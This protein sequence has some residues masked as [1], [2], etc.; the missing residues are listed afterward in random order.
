MKAKFEEQNSQQAAL[1]QGEIDAGECIVHVPTKIGQ[2]A[3]FSAASEASAARNEAGFWRDLYHDMDEQ[4]AKVSDT[5][6]GGKN[7]D[8]TAT[9]E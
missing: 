9:S 8:N 5:E 2:R 4:D 3:S 7:G 1:L 6:L